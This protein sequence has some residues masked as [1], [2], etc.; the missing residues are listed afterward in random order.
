M[1][2]GTVA[3]KGMFWRWAK[4]PLSTHCREHKHG[5]Q[6]D[7]PETFLVIAW[8]TE[9]LGRRWFAYIAGIG[10]RTWTS[11]TFQFASKLPIMVVVMFS[12]T[13]SSRSGVASLPSHTAICNSSADSSSHLPAHQ[14]GSECLALCPYP[15]PLLRLFPVDFATVRVQTRNS[16]NCVVAHHP[17]GHGGC[18]WFW[19]R[20]LCVG[21]AKQMARTDCRCHHG[22]DCRMV[23]VLGLGRSCER[24]KEGRRGGMLRL[25]CVCL[26]RAH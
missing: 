26:S 10:Q 21:V 7:L 18:Y 17:Q 15:T 16:Q 6:G 4:A 1:L 19:L 23:T 13:A 9:S 12:K 11:W 20:Q 24:R 8:K 25:C 5:V 22:L 14:L 3:V 2:P